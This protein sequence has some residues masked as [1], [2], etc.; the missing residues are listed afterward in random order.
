MHLREAACGGPDDGP[1]RRPPVAAT[2]K[3]FLLLAM[4]S[5]LVPKMSRL[6][7]L[8]YAEYLVGRV[9]DIATFNW[10]G[11]VARNLK[12][13]LSRAKENEAEARAKGR[14]QWPLGDIHFLM[15]HLLDFL[16]VRGF[17]TKTIPTCS[18]WFD[19]RV[20]KVCL[21]IPKEADKY[22]LG[23]MLL[24]REEVKSRFRPGRAKRDWESGS[25]SSASTAEW[26]K[27]DELEKLDDDE[28]KALESMTEKMMDVWESRRDSV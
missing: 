8:D 13:E 26:W 21:N 18:Y 25:S 4:G 6:C 2:V 10:S 3:Q 16:N 9:E 17:A 12:F 19:P 11:F 23:P 28:L 7:D 27:D 1:K 20:D 24:S 14:Q 15:I 5:M 22:L